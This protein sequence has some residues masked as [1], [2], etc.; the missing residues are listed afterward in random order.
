MLTSARHRDPIYEEAFQNEEKPKFRRERSRDF[1]RSP[2]DELM[3]GSLGEQLQS[4]INAATMLL[5]PAVNP[6]DA[7][8]LHMDWDEIGH[9]V[10]D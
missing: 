3:T 5:P 4:A 8:I 7:Q 1:D 10:A 9:D 2:S 6:D